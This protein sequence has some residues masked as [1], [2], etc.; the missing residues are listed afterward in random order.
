METKKI[1][2]VAGASI[3]AFAIGATLAGGIAIATA[4]DNGAATNN[5]ATGQEFGPRGMGHGMHG[6]PASAEETQKATDAILADY[7]GATV[8]MVMKEE[9]GT[10]EAHFMT[11][12]GKRK[13]AYLDADFK[14]TDVRNDQGPRGGHGPLGKDVTGKAFKKASKS[15]TAEVNG[16]VMG[17][18][19]SGKKYLVT[20]H[21]KNGNGVLV[22]EN[23][24]FKVL[25]TKKLSSTMGWHR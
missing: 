10:F 1:G 3:A 13:E 16:T 9:D 4:D 21:K 22:K 17:V 6:T 19:K 23:Q 5:T 18:H 12:D 24:N 15:A 7:P 8:H 11:S 20:V 25:S 2:A 14:I